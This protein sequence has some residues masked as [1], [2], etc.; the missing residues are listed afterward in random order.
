MACC[1]ESE[2]ETFLLGRTGEG[3]CCA[4]DPLACGRGN[5]HSS[6]SGQWAVRYQLTTTLS[7]CQSVSLPQSTPTIAARRKIDTAQYCWNHH[8]K[9]KQ[10]RKRPARMGLV[11]A[12]RFSAT[13]LLGPRRS[14]VGRSSKP[15]NVPIHYAD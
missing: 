10:G 8:G 6:W 12:N 13:C 11:P 5:S 14:L 15:C 1:F 9:R 3:G 2:S 4:V 7:V